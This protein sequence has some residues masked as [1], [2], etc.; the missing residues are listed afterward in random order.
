MKKIAVLGGGATAR[1]YAAELAMRGYGVRM[2]QDP[3]FLPAMAGIQ[4]A[5]GLQV[6]HKKDPAQTGFAPLE[7]LTDQM[8]PA[9]AGADVVLV[10]VPLAVIS[11]YTARLAP[12]LRQGQSVLFSPTVLGAGVGLARA[13]AAAG[14]E[15]RVLIIEAEYIRHMGAVAEDC[16]IRVDNL[17]SALSYAAWPAARQAEAEALV[18]EL[19]PDWVPCAD[20]W[21]VALRNT[22]AIFHVPLAVLNAGRMDEGEAFTFYARGCTP[23]VGGVVNALEAERMAVG[24]ALGL[25]MVP[26]ERVLKQWYSLEPDAWDNLGD[27]LRRNPFYAAI[28]A[29]ATLRHRF[30][31]EDIPFGL[32]PLE[33][34]A[35]AVRV[36]TP[37]L[38]ALVTLGQQ[39]LGQD[40]RAAGHSLARLGLEEQ[41]ADQLAAV[42]RQG[43]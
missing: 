36:E 22:N 8:E 30:L 17:K 6:C 15:A 26:L 39:L 43:L 5:G 4:K 34:L 3:D 20:I 18:G 7:L 23:A 25:D 21:E 13:M 40:F 41:T 9:L 19:F 2:Y 12:C 28:P 33:S 31:L 10:A 35:A 42:A 29:P 16:D 32:V 1:A 27:A 38:S 24:R 37:V 11:L 14:N